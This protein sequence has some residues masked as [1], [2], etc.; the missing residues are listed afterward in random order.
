MMGLNLEREDFAME[1]C[2]HKIFFLMIM[3]KEKRFF[4][5]HLMPR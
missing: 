3:R 5:F 4:P 1:S 2:G